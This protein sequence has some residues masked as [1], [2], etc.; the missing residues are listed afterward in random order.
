VI[1]SKI[2]WLRGGSTWNFLVGCSRASEGC[3]ACFAEVMTRRLAGGLGGVYRDAIVEGRWSGRVSLREDKLEEPA[4]WRK[5]RLVFPNSM[6]DTFHHEVPDAWL[7]RAFDVMDR[8]RHHRYLLL[9]KRG[10]R[11][12]AYLARRYPAGVPEHIWPGASVCTQADA[13]RQV[14]PLL[15]LQASVV[16]LSCEPLLERID[17]RDLPYD[18]GYH[19]DALTGRTHGY[20]HRG[21]RFEGAIRT[22]RIGWVIAGGETSF[23]ARPLHPEWVRS[24]RNQCQDAGV[25]F[26][27]KQWGEWRPGAD[28]MTALR[29]RSEAGKVSELATVQTSS[30]HPSRFTVAFPSDS[31]DDA[32]PV[33]VLDRVGRKRAGRELDG[34]I[35]DSM[36]EVL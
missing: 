28:R 30:G 14:P 4:R 7:D 24:L 20:D 12:A 34:K 22:N 13:Y 5:G 25:P 18:A 35:H 3:A 32:G 27:F 23:A 31:R 26:L 33:D 2:E 10:P 8:T 11:M 16:W 21:A 9:T 6:A 29:P 19:V 17:L 36:P 1:V 15:S